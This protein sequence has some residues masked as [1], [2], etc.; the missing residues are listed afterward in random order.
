VATWDGRESID[1]LCVRAG[2][3]MR[4]AKARGGDT[5]GRA[6]PSAAPGG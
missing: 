5:V 4:E 2:A 3:A 1:E 6:T